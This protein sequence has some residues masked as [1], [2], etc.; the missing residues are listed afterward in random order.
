MAMMRWSNSVSQTKCD[1]PPEAMIA[2][3]ASLFQALIASRSVRP[4]SMQRLIG[5][6]V[7]G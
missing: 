4:N 1:R 5:G 6:W 3:R 2:T 7:G